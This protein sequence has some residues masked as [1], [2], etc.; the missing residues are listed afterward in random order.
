MKGQKKI[1]VVAVGIDTCL[2]AYVPTHMRTC[3]PDQTRAASPTDIPRYLGS[4]RVS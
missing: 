3:V 4:L 2:R 1:P